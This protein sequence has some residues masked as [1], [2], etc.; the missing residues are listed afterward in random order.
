MTTLNSVDFTGRAAMI[1]FFMAYA[2]DSLTGLGVVDQTNNFFCK[3]LLFI[4]VV[5][6]LVIRKNEDIEN[7]KKL[8][9]ETTFY[10]KQWQATWKDDE[11]SSSS[12]K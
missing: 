12:R 7:I 2:V 3:T 10:D 1:G 9:E 11:N 5:G 8:L 4:A 6:V